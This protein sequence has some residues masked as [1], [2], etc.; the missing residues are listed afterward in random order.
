MRLSFLVTAAA[1]CAMPLAFACGSD[2]QDPNDPSQYG[3]GDQYGYGTQPYGTQTQPYGTQPQPT[4]TAQPQPTAQPQ[5]GSPAQPI[6]P[7]AAMA[8]QPLLAQLAASETQ[9]MQPDG[10]AFAGNFQQGQ[11]LEQPIQLQP[12][13]CYAVVGVGVLAVAEL[14]LE[15]V[16]DQPP[17]PPVTIAQDSTT[18]PQAVVGGR[19]N[20]VRN[21]F[22]MG[23]PAKVIMRVTSGSGIGMAQ[24]FSR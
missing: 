7:A 4:A 11:Y 15:I 9:G 17:A 22:P 16:A 23:G 18:G 21:P 10:P 8:A 12:G 19:N 5:G 2:T 13:K 14:D 1:F 6:P 20:C 3:Y 24:V